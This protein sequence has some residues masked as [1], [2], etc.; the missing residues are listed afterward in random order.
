MKDDFTKALARELVYEGGKVDNPKD[1]GGRTNQGVTNSTYNAW[2][3]SQGL[4]IR[5][6][7][8]MADAERDSIYD[9][10]YWVVIR[11]D[12]LPV[13]VDLCVFDASVN[14]GVGQA[15]RWLQAALGDHYAG[16]ADGVIGTKTMQAVLDF[17]DA[18]SL[19][20]AY[21]SRRLATLQ[22]LNTWPEFGKGWHARIANVQKASCA[23]SDA[24][25]EPHAVDVTSAGGHQK[26]HVSGNLKT[27][28]MTQIT[29]HVTSVATG[30]GAIVSQTAQQITPLQDTFAW[31]KWVFGGLTLG[32]V[33]LGIIAKIS[34]DAKEAAEKGTATATVDL[35]AEFDHADRRASAGSCNGSRRC[36]DRRSGRR[37]AGSRR[38][39]CR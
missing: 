29:A 5:D 38:L 4:P 24:A 3:R 6:V 12:D 14:S 35:E 36:G 15:A 21:C 23:W 33:V 28:P 31:L 2:R 7:Y 11:G 1:P 25:P 39:T 18:D 17:G 27:P 32:A 37:A 10:E 22:R 13:G 34:A 19:I 9:S 30:A 20:E 26:A 16:T 8:L